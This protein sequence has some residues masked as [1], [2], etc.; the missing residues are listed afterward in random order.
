MLTLALVLAV[1]VPTPPSSDARYASA[2]AEFESYIA[3]KSGKLKSPGNLPF[4]LTHGRRTERA[5]LIVHGLTDSPHYVR[6]LA[7]I[8]HEQGYNVAAILLPGH[9]TRPEDLLKV[10]AAEWRREVAFGLSIARRLGEKTSLAGFSA[11]GALALDALASGQQPFEGLYLFAPAIEIQ[12]GRLVRAICGAPWAT[13]RVRK[14]R[15][16]RAF[17][18]PEDNPHKY[19]KMAVNALCEVD[20]LAK[21]NG[22]RAGAI[23]AAIASDGTAVFMVQSEADGTVRHE[24]ALRFM[25]ALPAGTRKDVLLYPKPL[26]LKHNAIMGP[27]T[28]PRFDELRRRLEEFSR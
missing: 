18:I 2:V 14:W 17:K 4:L 6:A 5:I 8:F 9:G 21:A 23:N 13:T 1:S 28:N 10:K 7:E 19:R 26:G 20:G 25:D 22:R 16:T 24:G 3:S 27:A 11:G 12:R 15:E